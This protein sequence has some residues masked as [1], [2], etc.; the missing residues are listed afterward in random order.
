M[1]PSTSPLTIRISARLHRAVALPGWSSSALSRSARASSVRPCCCNDAPRGGRRLQFPDP[2]LRPLRDL[3]RRLLVAAG[4]SR[5]K[6]GVHEKEPS[7]VLMRR[8]E[9][10][11]Q[12]DRLPP[13]RL[14]LVVPAEDLERP[15]PEEP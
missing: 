11:V 7:Q 6:I 14:G 2:L 8:T 12:L 5:E 4:G 3:R 9:L 13:V 15:A 10:A 1:A